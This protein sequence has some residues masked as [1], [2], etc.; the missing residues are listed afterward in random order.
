MEKNIKIWMCGAQG[1]GK[2]TIL[3]LFK[4]AGFPVITEVVR[5]LAKEKGIAINQDGT[6]KSQEIIFST[7]KEVLGSTDKYISDRGLVD[8]LAYT[9]SGVDAGKVRPEISKQQ[10]EELEKFVNNTP[11][12]YI[13]YFP[14]E[15]GVVADGVRSTDEE[16][17]K[18]IDTNIREI[19]DNLGVEYLTVHGNPVERF[20]QILDYVGPDLV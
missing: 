16:Y 1:T 18:E 12:L 10:Y 4:E 11:N 7:Y 19:L 2:T 5:T 3:N 13:I 14:I 8:V 6:D 17:R 9:E 20:R 15:F